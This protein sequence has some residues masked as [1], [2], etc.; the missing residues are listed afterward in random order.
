MV[1]IHPPPL[2]LLTPI[3]LPLSSIGLLILGL[4]TNM[5]VSLLMKPG[6]L[7]VE[8]ENSTKQ[9]QRNS[10]LTIHFRESPQKQKPLLCKHSNHEDAVIEFTPLSQLV[11]RGQSNISP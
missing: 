3:L 4:A 8:T 9:H 10:R 1:K 5:P 2:K 11:K 6:G 7:V